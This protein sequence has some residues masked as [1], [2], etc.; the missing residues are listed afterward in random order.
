MEETLKTEGHLEV[1]NSEEFKDEDFNG[2]E[3]NE[4]VD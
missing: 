4:I 1:E 3:E 2:S